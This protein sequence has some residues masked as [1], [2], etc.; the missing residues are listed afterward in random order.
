MEYE[1]AV[2][3]E[4]EE[5]A[6]AEEEEDAVL[7]LPTPPVLPAIDSKPSVP[8]PLTSNEL[9]RRSKVIE[10]VAPSTFWMPFKSVGEG[11]EA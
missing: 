7:S 8:P 9:I 4:E 10:A 6:V 2:E 3:E 11:V 1:P 5:E